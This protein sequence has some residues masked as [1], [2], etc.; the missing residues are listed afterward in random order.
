MPVVLTRNESRTATEFSAAELETLRAVHEKLAI[1]RSAPIKM[2][3]DA[4]L[5]ICAVPE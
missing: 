1:A 2:L 4:W 3:D 5:C